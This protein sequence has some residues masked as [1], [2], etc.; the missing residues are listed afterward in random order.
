VPSGW[1]FYGL[2]GN[3]VKAGVRERFVSV[4]E[5]G[6]IVLQEC[7]CRVLKRWRQPYGFQECPQK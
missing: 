1:Y 3:L 7:Y 2:H 4:A 6:L 5:G